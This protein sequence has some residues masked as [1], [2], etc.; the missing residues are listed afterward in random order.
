MPY[1]L[2]SLFYAA[3]LLAAPHFAQIFSCYSAGLVFAFT[4]HAKNNLQLLEKVSFKHL[5]HFLH[6]CQITYF[7]FLIPVAFSF[8]ISD[9]RKKTF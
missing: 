7:T 4:L 3:R 1:N 2:R 5:Q 6:F 8:I 9:L